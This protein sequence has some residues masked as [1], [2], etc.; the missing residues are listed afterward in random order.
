MTFDRPHFRQLPTRRKGRANPGLKHRSYGAEAAQVEQ[1]TKLRINA[2]LVES[3][4]RLGQIVATRQHETR[5]ITELQQPGINGP[6]EW[7]VASGE[8]GEKA[9]S[10]FDVRG[11]T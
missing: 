10:T 5:P 11:P 9:G 4:G 6:N 1:P 7:I 3:L 8:W 2:G